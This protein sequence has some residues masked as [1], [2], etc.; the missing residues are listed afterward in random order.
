MP[1]VLSGVLYLACFVD[2]SDI[3]KLLGGITTATRGNNT[4]TTEWSPHEGKR[5]RERQRKRWRD[6]SKA[7]GTKPNGM[8]M[9]WKGNNG[10]T[11]LRPSSSRGL[12]TDEK[13]EGEISLSKYR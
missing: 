12:T 9:Q 11:M 2:Q 5:N 3:W 10:D 8:Q 7:S 13:E 4:A 6:E 1:Q